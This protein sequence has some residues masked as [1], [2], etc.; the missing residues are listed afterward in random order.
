MEWNQLIF[1]FLAGTAILCASG[2]VFLK[3]PVSS[4]FNLVLVFFNL[5]GIYALLGA[6]FVA[7]IQVLV[8]AG[9]VMVL[10]TFVIM[11]LRAD[12]ASLDLQ[13]SSKPI[14]GLVFLS[15]LSLLAVFI[16]LFRQMQPAATTPGPFTP[17]AVQAAGGNLQVMSELMFSSYVLPFELTSV[18]L[19]AAVVGV[20]A[21]AMRHERKGAK[22]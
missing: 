9:A 2:V 22:R 10:F 19:L 3:N 18:L 8:Y 14:Q 12:T 4:A 16:F 1:Y 7:A 17:E 13:R 11:L 21:I 15:G 6:H 20:V 5:A